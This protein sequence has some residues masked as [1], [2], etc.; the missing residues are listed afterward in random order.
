MRPTL[1]AV[2]LVAAG[3]PLTALVLVVDESLWAFAAVYLTAAVLL[4]ATDALLAVPPS[5][6]AVDVRTP[7]AVFAGAQSE[8][9]VR[10]GSLL[11]HRPTL[12]RMVCDV[13]PPLRPPP[14]REAV[15]RPGRTETVLLPLA[16]DRRGTATIRR[17]WMRWPGPMAMVLRQQIIPLERRVAIV[18]D[19]SAVR[20]AAVQFMTRD[21][22]YGVRVANQVGEG[23][24]FE[25]LKDYV[26]G[27]NTRDIDWKRSAHHRKL[28]CKEYRVERN[29]NV[30]LAFD[31]G[32]LMREPIDLLPRLD[33][34]IN[35]GL[36]L[37]YL[38][39]RGGD[40]VGLFAFDD[41]VRAFLAPTP[42][43][44]AL[45]RLQRSAAEIDYGDSETN[46]TLGLA[47]LGAR[48]RRRSLVVLFTEF[49]DTVTAEL[50]VENAARIVRRHLVIFVT[51]QDPTLRAT[52]DAPPRTVEDV[53]RA[54]VADDFIRD[55]SVVLER[56]RRLGA[57]CIDA[58][59][60]SLS[61]DLID[62]YLTVKRK[63]L[64]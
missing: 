25:E 53:A 1:R 30:I 10:L 27:L 38:S 49:T 12:V 48:L 21:A 9:L 44:H 42:N 39:L 62:R 34:A 29:Q 35:A 55:R 22:Y 17:L 63:E 6:L 33:H 54:V 61:V 57:Q 14:P 11:W 56:L 18:P 23:S 28:V 51:L 5:R 7:D 50:M 32:R 24:E 15:L 58:P 60:A 16:A 37:A 36:L 47:D 8:V 64:I 31:T 45:A 4:I 13:E 3:I 20:R 41:R 43:V 2:G 59:S 26:R 40:R 46:Y 52:L 19:V